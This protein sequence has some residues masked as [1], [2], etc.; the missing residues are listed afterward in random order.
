MKL[1]FVGI[2]FILFGLTLSAQESS[3]NPNP[4]A[5]SNTTET[6]YQHLPVMQDAR[7]DTLLERHIEM[8]K[9]LNGTD[10]YR[11]EIFFSSSLRAREEAM[12]VKT[13]F[14]KKFP[15]EQAYMIF[16]SPDFKVRVGNFRTKNEA[17]ALKAKIKKSY[18]NAFI[19]KDII[20]FPKLFTD[21]QSNE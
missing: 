1:V 8:N 12:E 7:I 5:S 2:F 16:R 3:Y 17:L 21:K 20:Q 11:L 9:R 19:V 10:G 14:L 6:V 4:N 15:E 18:P 13:E